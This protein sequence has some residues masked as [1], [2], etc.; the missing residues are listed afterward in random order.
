MTQAE[1]DAVSAAAE[2]AR[3]TASDA[4]AAAGEAVA[5]VGGKADKGHT[6]PPKDL[7]APVPKL[8]GTGA[9]TRAAAWTALM[10]ST[11]R[12]R[13]TADW[14][15]ITEPGVY[16]T[17]SVA[18]ANAPKGSYGYG[19]LEVAAAGDVTTRAMDERRGIRH[20]RTAGLGE[21][22]REHQLARMGAHRIRG[23]RG[24]EGAHA[25]LRWLGVGGRGGKQRRQAGDA[26]GDHDRGRG[27]RQRV[28]RRVGGRDHHGRGRLGGGGLPG[29]YPVGFYVTCK[30]GVDPNSV[31]GTWEQA[32]SVGPC[33]WLRIS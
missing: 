14:N 26:E 12:N 17:S 1:L 7:E 18:G 29:G 16:A 28:V 33:V 30:A 32:P 23:R 19:I 27:K 20:F 6:H 9:A 21:D 3:K 13:A 24:S 8:G 11:V 5:A 10:R 22:R 15:E 2:S 25:P 4:S 31:G